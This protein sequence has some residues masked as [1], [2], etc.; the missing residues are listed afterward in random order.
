MNAAPTLQSLIAGRWLGE[1][2]AVAMHSA[3]NGAPVAYTHAEAIDFGEAVEHARRV[4]VPALMAMDFQERAARL[5]A[6]GAYL[7][8][9]KE[10]LYAISHH[11]GA[12]RADSWVDIEGGSGTPPPS[13]SCRSEARAWA[14]TMVSSATIASSGAAPWTQTGGPRL[15]ANA[16]DQVPPHADEDRIAIMRDL[17]EQHGRF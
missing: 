7:L 8:Q 12:T 3:I 15:I 16:G 13:A 2:A 5:K 1:R 4:G 11:T 10:K 9:H 17:V 14:G 6:L